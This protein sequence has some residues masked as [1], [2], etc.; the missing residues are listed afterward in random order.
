MRGYVIIQHTTYRKFKTRTL[1]DLMDELLSVKSQSQRRRLREMTSMRRSDLA[2]RPLRQRRKKAG[3]PHRGGAGGTPKTCA[4]MFSA[5]TQPLRDRDLPGEDMR[6]LNKTI[7][8]LQLD[9]QG[10]GEAFEDVKQMGKG[11]DL[12]PPPIVA[13]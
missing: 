9:L 13:R 10:A 3:I 6:V 1:S 5:H 4:G 12:T 8:D 7:P 2:F 11:T